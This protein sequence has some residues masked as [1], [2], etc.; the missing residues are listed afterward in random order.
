MLLQKELQME[1]WAPEEKQIEG[2]DVKKSVPDLPKW[3]LNRY[4]LAFPPQI[5]TT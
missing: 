5:F 3:T 2:S 1:E 4:R